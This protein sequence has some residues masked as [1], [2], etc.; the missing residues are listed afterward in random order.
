[1]CVSC[2]GSLPVSHLTSMNQKSTRW[3]FTKK[4]ALRCEG[5]LCFNACSGMFM[6]GQLWFVFIWTI[7]TVWLEGFQSHTETFKCLSLKW[8]N[9][10]WLDRLL[11]RRSSHV[12][13]C[14]FVTVTVHLC[15]NRGNKSTPSKA[16]LHFTLMRDQWRAATATFSS[17]FHGFFFFYRF[18]F[19]TI[20][21]LLLPHI[22]HACICMYMHV[23]SARRAA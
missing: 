19:Q 20:P 2:P 3:Q 13:L 17:L 14:T 6:V 18:Q 22:V 10:T 9:W 15:L 23:Q 16:S 4:I 8:R 11:S 1:M 5:I 7:L 12:Q 21:R